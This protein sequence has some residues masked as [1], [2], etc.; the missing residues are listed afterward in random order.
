MSLV[1][2]KYGA[3]KVSIIGKDT[4]NNYYFAKTV[5]EIDG[6]EI[7]ESIVFANALASSERISYMQD[8]AAVFV[9]QFFENIELNIK[10][11][12]VYLDIGIKDN[13]AALFE[14]M[15]HYNRG[16][17]LFHILGLLSSLITIVFTWRKKK[18]DTLVPILFLSGLSTYFIVTSGISFWQGDRL[19]VPAIALWAPLYMSLL[20][21]RIGMSIPLEEEFN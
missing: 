16:T 15:S 6:L 8:N 18:Y 20:S 14:F 11:E 2:V 10:G 13:S 17:F 4:F 5:R 19:V 21:F 12:P 3:F 7:D 1:K 9:H